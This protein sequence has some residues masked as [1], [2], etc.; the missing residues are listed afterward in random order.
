VGTAHDDDA[1]YTDARE[2]DEHCCARALA[3]VEW[4]NARPEQSIAVV[5][6]SSFLRHLFMQFGQSLAAPDK[7]KIRKL[8]ANCELRSLVMCSHGVKDEAMGGTMEPA[9]TCG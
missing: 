2:T 5:T 8:A 7:A 9:V 6:H 4:L 3:F 1:S